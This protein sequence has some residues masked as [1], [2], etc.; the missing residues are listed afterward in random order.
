[1]ELPVHKRFK[2]RSRARSVNGRFESGSSLTLSANTATGKGPA[3]A[4]GRC[5]ERGRRQHNPNRRG[6]TAAT[7]PFCR[8][9]WWTS[10]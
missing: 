7:W 9:T 2:A 6:R 1:M 10:V 5:G 4:G 8:S 3:L